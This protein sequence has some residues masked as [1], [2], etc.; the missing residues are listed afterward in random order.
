MDVDHGTIDAT[1]YSDDEIPQNMMSED[2]QDYLWA[3]VC[4]TISP[5]G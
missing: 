2:D 1:L 3:V 4:M 5:A